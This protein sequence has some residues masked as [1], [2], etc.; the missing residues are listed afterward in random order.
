MRLTDGIDL[1]IDLDQPG[2]HGTRLDG[3]LVTIGPAGELIEVV[4]D[5]GELSQQGRIDLGSLAPAAAA[6]GHGRIAQGLPD[7]T[8]QGQTG[9]LGL[10]GPMLPIALARPD[11]DARHGRLAAAAT[12]LS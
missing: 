1:A 8:G 6:A 11:F 4:A 5:P 10:L 2:D 7:E 9:G 12:G 3:L